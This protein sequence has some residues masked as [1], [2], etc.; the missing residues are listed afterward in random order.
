MI[1][2]NM[3]KWCSVVYG[4]QVILTLVFIY[5]HTHMLNSQNS[6]FIL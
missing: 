1:I 5:S 4:V 3:H 2:A 6:P